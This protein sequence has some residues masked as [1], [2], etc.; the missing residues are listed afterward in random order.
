MNFLVP[1]FFTL[2]S[3][4]PPAPASELQGS[5]I[6][7][8]CTDTSSAEEAR[9]DA[10]QDG[11]NDLFA[12]EF[13]DIDTFAWDMGKIN[14]GR[15]DY[16]KM[17]DTARI[18]LS[19]SARARYFVFPAQGCVTSDFGLRHSIY[20]YGVDV[21]VYKGDS[22]RCAM[23]GIVRVIQ[24]DR[25]GYGKVV[26][27]RHQSGLET[28]YGHLS[29]TLVEGNKKIRAGDILGLGGSTGRSTGTHL[30]F[31]MRYYGEPFNPNFIVDFLTFKLKCDTLTLVK[32]DFN[33]LDEARSIV[34]HR[35]RNGE[36]LGHIAKTYGTSIQ[37]L[38]RLNQI[39][40]QT[41]LHIGRKLIVRAPIAA[42]KLTQR[43]NLHMPAPAMPVDSISQSNG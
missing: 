24:N 25:N 27:V 23:D 10:F 42:P 43:A 5:I 6:S 20:H 33:Y 9:E 14:S 38:C 35:I 12:S 2:A 8:V 7:A 32:N 40:P 21:K 41:L 16:T 17:V 11:L 13:G 28:I 18:I 36:T 15:F 37:T 1:F 19:D 34:C 31:E 39:T 4:M 30:H 3:L 29:K 22:I 26:V